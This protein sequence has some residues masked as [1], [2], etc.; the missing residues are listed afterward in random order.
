MNATTIDRLR[1]FLEEAIEDENAALAECA[2]YFGAAVA[3][4][5]ADDIRRHREEYTAIDTRLLRYSQLLDLVHAEAQR[6]P[7]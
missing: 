7:Q 4:D 1:A 3:L 5:I 6:V 2:E